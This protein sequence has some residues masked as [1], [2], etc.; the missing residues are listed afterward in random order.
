MLAISKNM[1]H[2]LHICIGTMMKYVNLP[3]TKE[4]EEDKI[5]S[6]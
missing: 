2:S 6:G 4:M 3:K 1:A 5:K